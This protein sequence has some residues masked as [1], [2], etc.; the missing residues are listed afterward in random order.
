VVPRAMLLQHVWNLNFDS[1][2][3]IIDVYVSRVRC[4]G[5]EMPR[6]ARSML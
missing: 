2:T 4:K 6:W 3:N 5:T 1:T